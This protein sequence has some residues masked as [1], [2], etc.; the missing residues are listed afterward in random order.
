[1]YSYQS[2]K[3]SLFVAF[4]LPLAIA[5]K[6][7][8][9]TFAVHSPISPSGTDAVSFTLRRIDGNVSEVKLFEFVANINSSGDVS[10]T[11]PETEIQSWNSPS[12]PLTFTRASGYGNNK[13][14]TYRFQ[15]KGN[16][17]T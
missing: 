15:V 14:I 9:E 11:T 16:N 2:L 13:L 12:F 5:C 17:K 7:S 4:C 3:R 8:P 1:M 10:A 6:Q